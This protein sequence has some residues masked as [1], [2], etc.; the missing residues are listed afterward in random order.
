RLLAMNAAGTFGYVSNT[1]DGT[2]TPLSFAP[3]PAPPVV[4]KPVPALAA[5]G[6]TTAEL[7]TMLTLALVLFGAGVVATM[8][9]SRAKRLHPTTSRR[10]SL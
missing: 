1:S 2:I 3:D 9:A 8:L 4:Q 5:T 7:A 6:T 10:G